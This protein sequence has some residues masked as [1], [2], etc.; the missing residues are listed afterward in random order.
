MN[1]KHV[2]KEQSCNLKLGQTLCGKMD[3]VRSLSKTKFIGWIFSFGF[4]FERNV[5]IAK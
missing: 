2:Y 1:D 3:K 5:G 4:I